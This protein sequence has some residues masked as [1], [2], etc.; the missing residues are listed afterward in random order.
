MQASF[1][2]TATTSSYAV[3]TFPEV[4][5]T[6]KRGDVV[7]PYIGVTRIYG[8]VRWER[9]RIGAERFW[10]A[11]S[12]SRGCSVCGLLSLAQFSIVGGRSGQA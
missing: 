10:L 1:S 2:Y 12:R 7:A 5:A 8:A 9:V 11:R 4:R 6:A 3:L